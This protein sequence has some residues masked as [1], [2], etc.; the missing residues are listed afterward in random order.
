MHSVHPPCPGRLSELSAWGSVLSALSA[1]SALEDLSYIVSELGGGL[2]WVHWVL[3][4]WKSDFLSQKTDPLGRWKYHSSISS[5]CSFAT[6]SSISWAHLLLSSI[7]PK[8]IIMKF[9]CGWDPRFSP[10]PN[11][12]HLCLFIPPQ[13]KKMPNRGVSYRIY[14]FHI[15]NPIYIRNSLVIPAKKSFDV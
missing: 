9:T 11:E 4:F 15:K 10:I 8:T 7:Q 6:K 5:F 12:C 13:S 3:R 1:L 2:H 14:S